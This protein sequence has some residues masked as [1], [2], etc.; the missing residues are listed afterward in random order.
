MKTALTLL[1][2]IIAFLLVGT[3]FMCGRGIET[4]V[5]THPT[6]YHFDV[7]SVGYSIYTE[8]MKL[9]GRLEYGRNS[10]L[11]SLIDFDNQ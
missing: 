4:V 3:G 9:I 6:E 2:L 5:I 10:Q 7:D 11:D 1:L 8:D